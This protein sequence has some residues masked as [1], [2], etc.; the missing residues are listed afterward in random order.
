ML[1]FGDAL[2]V[3]AHQRGHGSGSGIAVSKPVFQLYTLGNGI[4]VRLE[5]F[6][7]RAEALEAAESLTRATPP[8]GGTR[9]R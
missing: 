6:V 8:G 7:D 5:D 1:D 2:L 4:I 3:S 9:P